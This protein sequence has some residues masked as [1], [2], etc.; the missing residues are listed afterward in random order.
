MFLDPLAAD[1]V[2]KS[3]LNIT[4]I[5]LSIQ[6]EASKSFSTVLGLLR[7]TPKTPEAVFCKRLLSR[8][9]RLKQTHNRYHH[10]VMLIVS[11]HSCHGLQCDTNIYVLSNLVHLFS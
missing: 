1:T 6:R 7:A 9:N 11:L 10:M 4:L 2:F 8:L 5:P 3:T